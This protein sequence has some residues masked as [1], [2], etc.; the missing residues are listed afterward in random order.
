MSP[1]KLHG[2]L[3]LGVPVVYVGPA[4]SN[5]DRAIETYAC[6]FSL[7]QGDV[8]GLVEAIRRLRDDP[9]LASEL[10]RNARKAFEEAYSD[11]QTLP[12]F[13]RLLAEV[14]T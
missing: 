7:R 10:S 6:G 13:D 1:C 5:V 12:Q 3:A 9:S 4:G 11:E 14:T 8:D 2:A